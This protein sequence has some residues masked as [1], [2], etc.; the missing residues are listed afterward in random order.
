MM[1]FS[2][3]PGSTEAGPDPEEITA[4]LRA[5]SQLV[6]KYNTEGRRHPLISP[7]QLRVGLRRLIEPVMPALPILS[8]A[9]LPPQMPIQSL[10]TW[11]L[12][13]VA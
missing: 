13:D 4:A 6:T 5:L 11:E 2:P 3:R 9:E 12:P 8:L 7:P 1:L 10:G